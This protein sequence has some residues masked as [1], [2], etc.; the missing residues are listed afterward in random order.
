MIKEA[1]ALVVNVP[2]STVSEPFQNC[3]LVFPKYLL[4][5]VTGLIFLT[6]KHPSL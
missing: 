6:Q 5:L 4:P 2:Y 3:T 1:P